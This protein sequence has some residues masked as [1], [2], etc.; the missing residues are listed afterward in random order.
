MI[1]FEMSLIQGIDEP[2][3]YLY[4]Q[5]NEHTR[6]SF[7][8]K[9]EIM[10]FEELKSSLKNLK[11]QDL[12]NFYNDIYCESYN[13]LLKM[14]NSFISSGTAEY[15]LNYLHVEERYIETV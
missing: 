10:I 8:E 2:I 6:K 1:V 4:F 9:I 11:N 5:N 12:I 15:E 14:Q 3:K 13:L 7:I